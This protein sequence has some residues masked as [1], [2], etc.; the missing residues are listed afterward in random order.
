MD[1]KIKLGLD[2]HGVIDSDPT[3]FHLF[4]R[5]LIDKGHE[6]HIITGKELGPVLD[7]ELDKCC[8]DYTQI[9]SITSYHK[10]I[11]TYVSYKDGNPEWPLI[12]PPK[13]DPTKA[14][15][16][17]REDI[18]IMIDDSAVYGLYFEDIRT[19]YIR[20]TPEVRV[21]IDNLWWTAIG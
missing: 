7:D 18:D 12:A 5:H 8:V 19:Q 17:K 4:T 2:M 6:V 3:F 21:L 15:Y 13:W 16:C 14:M 11:G 9:F 1:K 10:S 20:W